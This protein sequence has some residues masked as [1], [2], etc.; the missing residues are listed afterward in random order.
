MK[1][2]TVAK[3]AGVGVETVRFYERERLIEQPRKP[4]NG[5]FRAYPQEA[6]VQIKFIRRAQDLGFSLKEVKELLSLRTDPSIDC[7]EIRQRAAMKL[8]E[9][10]DKIEQLVRIRDALDGVIK[11][12]PGRGGIR[13][14][15]ILEEMEKGQGT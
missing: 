12:C 11:A 15:S 4:V 2:S 14:C 9:V 8:Q 1:I 6:V 10:T 13:A 7:G 5:G 3:T